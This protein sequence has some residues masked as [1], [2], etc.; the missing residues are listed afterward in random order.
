MDRGAW[1]ATVYG[2][3][4][5]PDTTRHKTTTVNVNDAGIYSK[6]SDEEPFMS[7]SQMHGVV[8]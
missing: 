5:E 6:C 7:F 2:V 8:R 3:A 1:R 4:E